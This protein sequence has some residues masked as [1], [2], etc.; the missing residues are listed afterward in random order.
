VQSTAGLVRDLARQG[1]E[2][3]RV[4]LLLA[5]S[6]IAERGNS[7]LLSLIVVGGGLVVLGIGLGLIF[8]SLSLFVARFVSLD[9]A[10]LVVAVITMMTGLLAVLFGARRLQPSKLL[11]EKSFSQISSLLGGEP[12]A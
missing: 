7:A 8:V 11:P 5:R 6:E 2:L 1:R 10:F 12:W 9:L 3:L 4:E